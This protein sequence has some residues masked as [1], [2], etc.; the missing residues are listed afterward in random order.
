MM[1]FVRDNN[2]LK[3]VQAVCEFDRSVG[4]E[5]ELEL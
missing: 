1:S 4:G 2:T 3:S 5:S